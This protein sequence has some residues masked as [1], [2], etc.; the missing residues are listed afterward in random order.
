MKK[1]SLCAHHAQNATDWGR[2]SL[3]GKIGFEMEI[4]TIVNISIFTQFIIKRIV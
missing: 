1:K 4:S 3:I 2:L